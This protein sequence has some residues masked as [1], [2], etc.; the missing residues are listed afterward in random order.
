MSIPANQEKFVQDKL[1]KNDIPVLLTKLVQGGQKEE[2]LQ[3][4]IAWGTHEKNIE[5]VYQE[6]KAFLQVTP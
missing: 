5:T 6:A 2:A 1:I 3:L 4:L